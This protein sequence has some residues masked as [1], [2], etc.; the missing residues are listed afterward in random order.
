MVSVNLSAE[1]LRTPKVYRQIQQLL[2]TSLLPGEKLC[3]ELA[4]DKVLANMES[5]RAFINSLKP[6]GCH[7]A[8]DRFG[9][10]FSSCVHLKSL[11]VDWIKIDGQ[12]IQRM[13]QSDVDRAIVRSMAELAR[14]VGIQTVATCVENESI[15]KRLEHLGVDYLQGY[16]LSE[17]TL[18]T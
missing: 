8:L 2:Q 12:F 9:S 13:D 17:P 10:G 11:N 15:R 18:L 1:T 5:T 3:F 16:A 4:E 14:A 7:F 6:L